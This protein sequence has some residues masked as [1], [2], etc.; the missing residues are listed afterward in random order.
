MS[1]RA[2]LRI[3]KRGDAKHG[4]YLSPFRRSMPCWLP[5][6]ADRSLNASEKP[7]EP[8]PKSRSIVG[9]YNLR[10]RSIAILNLGFYVWIL[11]AASSQ[12]GALPARK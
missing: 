5:R 2:I 4:P 10:N 9:L 11:P 6:D 12:R 1:Y 7:E 8:D 3:L